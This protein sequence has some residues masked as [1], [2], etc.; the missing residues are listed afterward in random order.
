VSGRRRYQ[1]ALLT[2]D[3][4]IIAA[5]SLLAVMIR[6][7]AFFKPAHVPLSGLGLSL[8][9]LVGAMYVFNLYDL[10]VLRTR[11][12]VLSRQLAAMGL[13]LVAIIFVFYVL[14]SHWYGR[15]VLALQV[16]LA[17]AGTLTWRLLFI[18]LL[19]RALRSKR[20]L[21]IGAGPAARSI[22]NVLADEAQP[23]EVVGLL[24]ADGQATEPRPDPPVLGR[25]EQVA[26]LAE[27]HGVEMVVVASEK[28]LSPPLVGQ[29]LTLKLA[30]VECEEMPALYERLTGRIPAEHIDDEWLLASGGFHLLSHQVTRRIKRLVDIVF[31]GAL[32]IIL[33]PLTL[34]TALL[35][36][37]DSPGPILY[38]QTRTGQG[39]A[40][41]RL[42][43]FR[44]MDRQAEANGPQWAAEDDDRVTRVGRWL[45][46]CR[47]DEVPQL[48][49][50]LAGEMSLV[51][52]RPERPEFVAS[53]A[54]RLPYYQLRHLVR[55][56]L[57]GWAQI[58]FGYAKSVEDALTKL[59]YELYYVKNMSLLFDL[60]IILKT[61]GVVALGP[62]SR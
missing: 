23:Y 40:P 62:G 61:I 53:L 7:G 46:A 10:G 44:S 24:A 59:E 51:G 56:G 58:N 57:T 27:A 54:Q 6:F 20:L 3:V 4:L 36:K 8:L 31:G 52:P 32:L 26:Q 60:K 30:G 11:Q 29:L 5:A 42:I 22:V 49:N 25:P 16:V 28:K 13:G 48:I 17:A 41:F 33:S 38:V 35:V 39:G 9:F 14:P 37:L 43:K 45:R 34:L 21:V 55:P 50:V 2:G 12:V 18:G 47:L 19:P 1:L 15:G